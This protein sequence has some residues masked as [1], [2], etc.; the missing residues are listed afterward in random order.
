M[1]AS[2][3]KSGDGNTSKHHDNNNHNRN[4]NIPRKSQANLAE[5][6]I[7]AV[8]INFMRTGND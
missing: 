4:N 6:V 8:E 2:F 1:N 7:V 3:I 5:D